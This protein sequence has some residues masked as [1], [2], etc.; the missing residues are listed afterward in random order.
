[1]TDEHFTDEFTIYPVSGEDTRLR[2][3]AENGSVV[4]TTTEADATAGVRL[5]V[6]EAR[7]LANA[8]N[9]TADRVERKR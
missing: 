6:N 7:V 4:V 9:A 1:M 8:L 2:V 3:T 5:S